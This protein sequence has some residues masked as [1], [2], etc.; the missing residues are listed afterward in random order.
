MFFAHRVEI[1]DQGALDPG[2][3][4]EIFRFPGDFIAKVA[5]IS[6]QAENDEIFL[7]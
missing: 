7:E 5:A 4:E 3:E 2:I 1:G 6:A